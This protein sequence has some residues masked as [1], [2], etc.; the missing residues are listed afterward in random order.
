M[1]SVY[2]GVCEEDGML[3]FPSESEEEE[4]V[5]RSS[6]DWGVLVGAF[7]LRLSVVVVTEGNDALGEGLGS[8]LMVG[9]RE[10]LVP[11]M[12]RGG[13]ISGAGSV[14]TLRPPL[15]SSTTGGFSVFLGCF[16]PNLI[17]GFAPPSLWAGDFCRP[18][19]PS[20]PFS[21]LGRGGAESL[22]L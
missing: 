10:P 15:G 9:L 19:P 13:G 16:L 3:S 1:L 21:L 7:V 4:S 20:A 2:L 11:A 18:R 12:G 6:R 5:E 8:F 22:E 14:S 17:R